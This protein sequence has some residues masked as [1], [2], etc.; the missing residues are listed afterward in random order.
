MVNWVVLGVVAI[1]I[2]LLVLGAF[3]RWGLFSDDRENAES[4][5]ERVRQEARRES[6]YSVSW[7]KKHKTLTLPA[8]VVS[9]C[10]VLIVLSTGVYTYFVLKNGAP[11]EVPYAN[12]VKASTIAVIGLAAGVVYRGSKEGGRGRL[13]IIYED[14]DG[15]AS[16][17][18]TIWFEPSET[19]TNTDGNTVIHE[20]FE[21]RI[22]GLFGRRKLVAHDR[23]LRNE[24]TVL[25]DIVGH[26][27]PDHAVRVTENH[28]VIRTQGQRVKTGPSTAADYYYRSPIELPYQTYLQQRERTEKLEMRL[29][30]KDAKL[31]EAQTLLRD[32]RRRLETQEY[33]NVE[34]AREEI[35]ATL[36]EIPTGEKTV[37][38]RQ[39]K[40]RGRLPESQRELDNARK[41]GKEAD[42]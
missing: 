15:G 2:V 26:E 17:T 38:V 32:L 33:R 16:D 36:K 34:E 4:G 3:E 7:L 14:D 42:A 18:D 8:K 29:D 24:R 39:D 1:V 22:F 21:R 28:Y 11:V 40:S 20:H 9:L 41:N 37:E 31:A 25:G 6:D 30:T 23:E 19:T 12:S 27:I 5:T 13:D 10:I 35:K